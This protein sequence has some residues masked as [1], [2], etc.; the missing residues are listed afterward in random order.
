M[1]ITS[2][3]SCVLCNFVIVS[4]TQS[5]TWESNKSDPLLQLIIPITLLDTEMTPSKSKFPPGF[6]NFTSDSTNVKNQRQNAPRVS[7]LEYISN[8]TK[9]VCPESSELFVSTY[10]HVHKFLQYCKQYYSLVNCWTILVT[11][12]LQSIELVIIFLLSNCFSTY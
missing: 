5:C 6:P 11:R 10:V 9:K 12:Y 7:G 4:L 3:F 8:L 2:R 1:V